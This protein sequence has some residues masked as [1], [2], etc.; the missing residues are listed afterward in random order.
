MHANWVEHKLSSRA[1]FLKVLRS[2]KRRQIDDLV[3]IVSSS[4]SLNARLG[5]SV[6][7]KNIKKA[8]ERN[9]AKRIQRELFRKYSEHLAGHDVIVMPNA[10][11]CFAEAKQSWEKLCQLLPEL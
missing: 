6:A 8:V 1:E 5:I 9:Y 2:G 7:K 10:N 11:V 3:F 4:E